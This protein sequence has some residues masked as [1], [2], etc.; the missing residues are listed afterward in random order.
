MCPLLVGV[1]P[2]DI[3]FIPSF[4]GKFIEDWIVQ[5][6]G[7]NQD[8]GRVNINIRATRT[9]G[10]QQSMNETASKK[11][12]ALAESKNLIG[13]N[14]TLEAWDAYAWSLPPKNQNKT[15]AANPP[16]PGFKPAR[17]GDFVDM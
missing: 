14:A 11:F 12:K 1:K 5:T 17:G 3:I 15:P 8:D 6:V 16:I 9:F 10:Q 4:T 13:P 2:H 7:Y